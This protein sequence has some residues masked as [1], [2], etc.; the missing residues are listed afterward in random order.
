MDAQTEQSKQNRRRLS[1]IVQEI[2]R[3]IGEDNHPEEHEEESEATNSEFKE[4]SLLREAWQVST[5]ML[6]IF[7]LILVLA[8]VIGHIEGWDCIQR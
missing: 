5:Y 8:V 3:R 7:C 1:L 2:D 6:P 4:P